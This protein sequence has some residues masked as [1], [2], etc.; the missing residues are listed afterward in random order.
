MDYYCYVLFV[1]HFP[2]KTLVFEHS[3]FK[4]PRSSKSSSQ[5]YV[6]FYLPR[7]SKTF[8]RENLSRIPHSTSKSHFKNDSANPMIRYTVDIKYKLVKIIKT[9]Y[10]RFMV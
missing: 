4:F 1:L 3:Y 8:P 10:G 7:E 5:D 2:I 9:F 6:F